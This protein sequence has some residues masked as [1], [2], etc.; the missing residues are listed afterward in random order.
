MVMDV[1]GANHEDEIPSTP[2]PVIFDQT[3]NEYNPVLHAA[4]ST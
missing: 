3:V 4:E 2:D 1:D